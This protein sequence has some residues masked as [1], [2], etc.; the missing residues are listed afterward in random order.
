MTSAENHLHGEI[1]GSS[2]IPAADLDAMRALMAATFRDFDPTRFERDLG[3]KPWAILLR[4]TA[5]AIAGFS[6]LDL[7]SMTIDGRVIRAV[8]SGDTVIAASHRATTALPRAFLRFLARH[9]TMAAEPG[10]W[11]WFYVCK[12]FRTYRFLPVFY[13]KFYPHPERVTPDLEG[14]I[15]DE[16]AFRRFGSD[17]DA[18]S[19]VVRVAGDY[20]LADAANDLTE[21]RLTDPYIRFFT[22]R[23]PG[24]PHGEE[25]VCLAPLALGNLL[26]RPRRWLTEESEAAP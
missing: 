13:R 1:L 23:N 21:T 19:G 9:T 6:T 17:Y 10:S 2:D 12:G 22:T 25:L 4:D 18:A 3:E 7:M 26:D 5:G 14:K 8:Y 15:M 16:L 11:F 20:A 24:W